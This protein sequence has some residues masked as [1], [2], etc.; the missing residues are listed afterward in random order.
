MGSV[1][2]TTTSS[3]TDATPWMTYRDCAEYIQVSE[4]YIRK[5]VSRGRLPAIK[6]SSRCVRIHRD[7]WFAFLATSKRRQRS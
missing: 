6:I 3:A 7:D 5:L 1:T 4:Q 2:R